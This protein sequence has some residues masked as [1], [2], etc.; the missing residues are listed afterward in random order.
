MSLP[1][2][3]NALRRAVE[4][5]LSRPLTKSEKELIWRYFNSRCAFCN[6]L[7]DRV[8]R[9]GHMDHL[10]C[11]AD[12]GGNY[13]RN[14]VLACKECNGNEKR[15]QGWQKF[16]K[17]KCGDLSTFK[18]RREKI[19]AWQI[20]FPPLPPLVLTKEAESARLNL[21]VAI[22]NVEESFIRFRSLLRKSRLDS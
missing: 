16:L 18:R 4:E 19:R 15:E 12:G 17:S 6:K 11:S 14:R 10:D 21:D 22:N 20:Q 7:V 2:A 9:H 5:L 3:K 13:I 1:K 8:A